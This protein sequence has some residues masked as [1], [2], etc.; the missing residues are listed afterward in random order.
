MY[1]KPKPLFY[2]IV[3]RLYFYTIVFTFHFVYKPIKI[4][5]MFIILTVV[6]LCLHSHVSIYIP[7]IPCSAIGSL[8]YSTGYTHSLLWDAQQQP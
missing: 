1:P 5:A 7:Y 6:I 2:L 8:M 3:I 4:S